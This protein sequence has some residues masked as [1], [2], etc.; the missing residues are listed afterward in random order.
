MAKSGISTVK[1][2]QGSV[3][4]PTLLRLSQS[5]ATLPSSLREGHDP[6]MMHKDP[7]HA[8]NRIFSFYVCSE[9]YVL[10]FFEKQISLYAYPGQG[11]SEVA[12]TETLSNLIHCR[13]LLDYHVDDLRQTL[14][15]VQGMVPND[16]RQSSTPDV[17]ST[18]SSLEIDLKYL[19]EKAANLR[20]RSETL[21][22]LLMNVASIGEV[23]RSVHQNRALFRFTIIASVYVPLSFVATLFGMNFRQFGQGDLSIWIYFA[24]SVPVFLISAAFLFV[25]PRDIL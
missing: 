3:Q 19:V 1:L 25:D 21:I 7:L 6:N 20:S 10:S 9:A 13:R 8:L 15:I 11:T 4:E 17:I 12:D 23:R 5:L 16:S 14:R 2:D 24:V 18:K 22:G